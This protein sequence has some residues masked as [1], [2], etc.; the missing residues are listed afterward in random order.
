VSRQS[1]HALASDDE[2]ASGVT[3]SLRDMRRDG[4]GV[5][6]AATCRSVAWEAVPAGTRRI[7]WLATW[8]GGLR[9]DRPRCL[10][11]SPLSFSAL[12]EAQQP[13]LRRPRRRCARAG[14]T[15]FGCSLLYAFRE[16]LPLTRLEGVGSTWKLISARHFSIPIPASLPPRLDRCCRCLNGAGDP[17][18]HRACS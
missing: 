6:S 7:R 11:G 1:P 16:F 17:R 12:P 15:R 8:L 18:E 5:C 13:R 3:R 2:R 10:F 14:D 4:Y 9:S